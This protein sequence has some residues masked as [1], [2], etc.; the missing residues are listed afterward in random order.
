MEFFGPIKPPSQGKK[1]ILVC[2]NYTTKWVEVY[3]LMEAK[4]EKV[5]DFLY[6][7]NMQQFGGPN[8]FYF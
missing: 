5:A 8:F 1:H 4:E 2:A 3:A 7:N 6:N